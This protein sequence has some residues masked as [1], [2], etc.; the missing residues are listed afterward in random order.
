M[1]LSVRLRGTELICSC[2]NREH[3]Y[4][5]SEPMVWDRPIPPV[6]HHIWLT[7]AIPSSLLSACRE[8]FLKHHPKWSTVLHKTPEAIFDHP[9]L[10]SIQIRLRS[11]YSFC[12][13]LTEGPHKAAP[14][15]AQADVLRLA[16]LYV[17]GG[18]YVDYDMYCKR[19]LD[20]FRDDDLFLVNCCDEPKMVT[21]AV[22]GCR[23]GD[24]RIYSVLSEFLDCRPLNGVVTPRLTCWVN[25]FGWKSYPS[26]CFCP[27]PRGSKDVYRMTE[28][29]HGIHCWKQ[30]DYDARKLE[31]A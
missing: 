26:E 21:E 1:D 17:M 29:T 12:G 23:T 14:W 28:N 20:V 4:E 9:A 7:D 6:L 27:H 10:S 24:P 13:T 22:M 5:P 31:E 16:A 8:S 30:N 2:C 19:P 25:Q 11:F 18:F 3:P 15:A